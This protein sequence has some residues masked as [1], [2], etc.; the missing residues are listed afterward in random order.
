MKH[1][2]ILVCLL[3]G[4]GMSNAQPE[5]L[6]GI[7]NRYA[8][9]QGINYCDNSLLLSSTA[10]FSVGQ[11]VLVIQMQGAEINISNSPAF[12]DIT[13]LGSAGR[14]ERGY[15]RNIDGARILLEKALINEYNLAGAVQVVSMPAYEEAIVTGT[16]TAQAWDGSTGGILAFSVGQLRLQGDIDLS[17]K[18]F[19][20]GSFE[21][22]YTG[23]CTF[24]SSYSNYAYEEGS[25]RGGKKG[26]GIS[27]A[28]AS[29]SRGRG[30][31]A[32]GGGGG[33]DHNS[34]G[35]GGGHLSSGGVG[36]INDNPATFG[37]RGQFPG[38]GGKALPAASERLYLGGGG[39]AGH[40]NN[41]LA[42]SGGA[43]GGIVLIEASQTVNEG[44]TI[45]ARGLDAGNATGDGA[46]GGGAGGTIAIS[47]I[48]PNLPGI[49][50]D[51]RGGRGG[52]ADNIN[53]N[54]CFG[55][56]GGG[57]G[58]RLLLDLG[59]MAVADLAGGEPGLSINSAQCSPSTNGAQ[60][61][62]AGS[63]ESFAP[64][65]AGDENNLPPAV[66]V[67]VPSYTACAG[68]LLQLPAL[69]QG[70]ELSFQWQVDMGNGFVAIDPADAVYSQTDS[71]V[72]QI[73]A[74]SP[75]MNDYAYRLAVST[76]CFPTIFSEPI[77]V[78]VLAGPMADFA[79]TATGLA[80]QLANFSAGA[81]SYSWFFGDGNSSAEVAPNHNYSAAGA[82]EVT[83]VAI[84]ACGTDT[85]RQE[86]FVGQ[87]PVA[88]FAAEGPRTGCA[89]YAL[90]FVDQ[91]TGIYDSLLWL[92][93][94]GT[95][96]SSTAS[97][98]TVSYAA[99]GTYAVELRLFG[100]FGDGFVLDPQAVVVL[101]RP[102]P[103]F[104]FSIDGLTVSFFNI[105]PFAES[106]V[107]NFG[108]GNTSTQAEPTH[109]YAAPGTY[110]VTLNAA[111]GP[112]AR[113][114]SQTVAIMPTATRQPQLPAGLRLFPNP[115]ASRLSLRA[116]LPGWY[117]VRWRLLAADGRL[118]QTGTAS[119]DHDW[120]LEWLPAGVYWM[121]LA[122][123]QGSWTG[124]LVKQ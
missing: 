66:Q 29:R 110:S 35:G 77:F 37:C 75:A 40:G 61:G 71:P 112:C 117:P 80:V 116:D 51:V 105:T 7:I 96:A 24:L 19:R 41:D 52:N 102:D 69:V 123:A 113:A 86:V 87:P 76:D 27:A 72:L 83:L 30:A 12:G 54:Q 120:A 115:F 88:A 65:P 9:V 104:D 108:D 106:Y 57:A 11:A 43:G 78:E 103:D 90:S 42:S 15:I 63:Q 101:S 53:A 111:N 119:G 6:T 85:A 17:G 121:E 100:P 94:G 95:P 124:K 48:A 59:F 46:G 36:G 50:I 45:R 22:D 2:S 1:F 32:N 81:D 26:E 5:T 8:A 58:G 62:A 28:P 70:F 31:Q 44:G 4:L 34:G 122:N 118:V 97:N 109:T 3:L 107:W 98:P 25:I 56:G 38:S 73:N 84:N 13:N 68:S 67:Q 20:G 16:L 47:G 39:G 114:V 55:P 91:S 23:T 14:Y 33:N 79:A 10:G 21:L 64:I 60:A 99:P 93:P 74:L 82:Y 18:G 49:L 92:F 89:P